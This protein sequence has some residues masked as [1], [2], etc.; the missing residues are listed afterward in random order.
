MKYEAVHRLTK[1]SSISM[2]TYKKIL[3][4]YWS[5]KKA[6]AIG[7][8]KR[9]KIY[10]NPGTPEGRKRGGINSQRKFQENTVYTNKAG[11]I[12]RKHI[13]TPGLSINLAEFIGILL[14]DGGITAHQVAISF[15]RETD[16]EHSVYIQKLINNLYEKTINIHFRNYFFN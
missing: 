14:G 1:A 15:N 4:D 6:G 11:F 7:A 2:G 9:Y 10:G 8:R 5:T 12:V 13:K 16:K 3:P